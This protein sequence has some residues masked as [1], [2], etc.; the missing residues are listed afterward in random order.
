MQPR[1]NSAAADLPLTWRTL[2]EQRSNRACS[3]T[4]S[5]IRWWISACAGTRA[6][7][8]CAP[9]R[10]WTAGRRR[11]TGSCASACAAPCAPAGWSM[12]PL[13]RP[14]ERLCVGGKRIF[15]FRRAVSGPF[16]AACV[17]G[18]APE[19]RGAGFVPGRRGLG[20]AAG[21]PESCYISSHSALESQAFYAA[22]GC[23][24]AVETNRQH[25]EAEPFD[26]QLEYV[27]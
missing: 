17:G 7:G 16:G 11:T 2:R 12:P 26:R 9:A 24:D 21:R 14:A 15:W 5:A 19:R 27:L 18:S 20:P 22:M 4:S 1:K 25:V 3:A 6:G 23:V 8:P 10:S 13:R